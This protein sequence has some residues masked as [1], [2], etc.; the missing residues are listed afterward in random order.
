M[1]NRT[2]VGAVPVAGVK[3]P[4]DPPAGSGATPPGLPPPLEEPAHPDSSKPTTTA[5]V[6]SR[7]FEREMPTASAKRTCEQASRQE[8][9]DN[10]T[11]RRSPPNPPTLAQPGAAAPA[12]AL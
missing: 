5:A 10:K 11:E 4:V 2:P 12:P 7:D 1:G 8:H 6:Q 9:P 3:V